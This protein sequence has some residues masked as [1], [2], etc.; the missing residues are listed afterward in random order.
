M[1]HIIALQADAIIIVG[2]NIYE[3][4][5]CDIR[6]VSPVLGQMLDAHAG[7]LKLEETGDVKAVLYFLQSAHGTFVT[8]QDL[9]PQILAELALLL[10]KY[11]VGPNNPPHDL[12]QFCFT[13]HTLK[14]SDLTPLDLSAIITVARVLGVDSMQQLLLSVFQNDNVHREIKPYGNNVQFISLL[15]KYTTHSIYLFTNEI[16]KC[17]I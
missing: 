15:C 17:L 11:G 14:P 1:E 9:T 13:K 4:S 3:V 8:Y 12:V 6:K 16:S 7:S 2:D 10:E 5:S